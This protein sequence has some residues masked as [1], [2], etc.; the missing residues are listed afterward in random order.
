MI[1]L[2]VLAGAFL[3]ALIVGRFSLAVKV[4][5]AAFI[6]FGGLVFGVYLFGGGGMGLP[7]LWALIYWPS[8]FVIAIYS[9]F[10]VLTD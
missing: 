1:A 5:M 4:V 9:L 6:C 7:I 2:V 8:W 3:L 10:K